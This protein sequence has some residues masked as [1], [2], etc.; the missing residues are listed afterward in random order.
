MHPT[1]PMDLDADE[2]DALKSSSEFREYCKAIEKNGK[3]AKAVPCRE[4]V[5]RTVEVTQIVLGD[6]MLKLPGRVWLFSDKDIVYVC[7]R[8][9]L[10]YCDSVSFEGHRKD[11]SWT[12]PGKCVYADR[13]EGISVVEVEGRK[14]EVLCR[15]I[16][17]IGKAFI[18]RKTLYLDINGYLFY[19]LLQEGRVAGFFSKEKESERHNLSCLLVLPPYRSK[20]YGSLMI[21]LSYLLG[22]GTPEKPLSDDGQVAYRKYWK[23]KV[24][25][26]LQSMNGEQASIHDISR[27]SGLTVDDT[28]HG[29]ELL[30]IDP[31]ARAYDVRG[32]TPAL[33][34]ECKKKCL[35]S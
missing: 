12:V 21:D 29:L 35:I 22:S 14:E 26:A 6:N 3:T 16:C 30:G 8:C 19:V 18:Q 9:L 4:F 32:K 2:A 15:R 7:D 5:E 25:K 13:D 27:A 11:C 28:V 20:G 34:R 17:T 24:L 31:R 10:Q 33:S 1:K 23:N